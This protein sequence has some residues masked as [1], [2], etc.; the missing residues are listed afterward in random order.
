M[1]IAAIEYI[2]NQC[3]KDKTG[4]NISIK[5]GNGPY[6]DFGEIGAEFSVRPEMHLL[7]IETEAGTHFID[8]QSITSMHI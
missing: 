1:D 3:K 8:S 7:I 2:L 4:V 5:E 6:I